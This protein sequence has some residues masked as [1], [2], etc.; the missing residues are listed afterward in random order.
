[1]IRDNNKNKNNYKN[2]DNI[3]YNKNLNLEIQEAFYKFIVNILSYF[4][5]LMNFD[6]LNNGIKIDFNKD[7]E[8]ELNN[9]YKN[10][11]RRLFF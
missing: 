8:N 2:E 7:Y 4:Y 5:R 10:F 11:R 3:H 1:M 9:K 6:N